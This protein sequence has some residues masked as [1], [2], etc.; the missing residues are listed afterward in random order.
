MTW[1]IIIVGIIL[2][3]VD[4]RAVCCLYCRGRRLLLPGCSFSSF[5]TPTPTVHGFWLPGR[6]SSG[7]NHFGLL[8]TYLGYQK[9]WRQ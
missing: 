4:L 7:S 6:C 8:H 9:I 3:L 2:I 5:A 1:V